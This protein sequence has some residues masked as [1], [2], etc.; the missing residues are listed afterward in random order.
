M[1]HFPLPYTSPAFSFPLQFTNTLILMNDCTDLISDNASRTSN[2]LGQESDNK[3]AIP[4]TKHYDFIRISEIIRCE[5]WD[6]YTR[7]HISD[8]RCLL[9]SYH[10]GRFRTMLQAYGFLRCHKS[11]LI[12]PAYIHRYVLEG[13]VIMEDGSEVPVARRKKEEFQK[14]LLKPTIK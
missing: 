8:G 1:L 12:N 5:G 10:I 3:I 13:R 2:T 7:I 14:Q 9:S 4:G 11:H 6:K